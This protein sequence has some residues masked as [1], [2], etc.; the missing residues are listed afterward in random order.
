[1][2]IRLE[3][4]MKS[5]DSPRLEIQLFDREKG[6]EKALF[7]Q[8]ITE[9]FNARFETQADYNCSMAFNGRDISFNLHEVESD[10]SDLIESIPIF[11]KS[12]DVAIFFF[13]QEDASSFELMEKKHFEIFR[14]INRTE[15]KIIKVFIAT[16]E[17]LKD[18]DIYV[19]ESLLK[20]DIIYYGNFLIK[21]IFRDII[22]SLISVKIIK[23]Q[24]DTKKNGC[25]VA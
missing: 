11:E 4:S 12:A 22:E 15:K 18:K 19:R 20:Y 7:I 16:K 6:K 1:M 14:I 23:T 8:K 17:F 10:D 24:E 2:S 5:T 9:C 13:G 21:K 3:D 25:S